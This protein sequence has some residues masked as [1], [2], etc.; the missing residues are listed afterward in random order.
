MRE[1]VT[2]P[3][4]LSY[5]YD[6]IVMSCPHRNADVMTDPVSHLPHPIP[7]LSEQHDENLR[8]DGEIQQ[9]LVNCSK[10]ATLLGESVEKKKGLLKL[11]VKV[12]VGLESLQIGQSTNLPLTDA[13]GRVLMKQRDQDPARLQLREK[14]GGRRRKAE[15]EAKGCVQML[16]DAIICDFCEESGPPPAPSQEFGDLDTELD[17]D[18]EWCWLE[19]GRCLAYFHNT[20][21]SVSLIDPNSYEFYCTSCISS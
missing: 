3:I 2:L 10:L 9:T 12:N 5:M 8:L 16:A 18:D 13:T 15:L 1:G 20:C 6:V 4:P 7:D 19:C 17:V 11:L 21:V 14:R